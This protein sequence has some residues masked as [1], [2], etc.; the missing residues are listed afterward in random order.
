MH[1]QS[2]AWQEIGKNLQSEMLKIQFINLDIAG[3]TWT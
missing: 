3:H 1:R 2:T